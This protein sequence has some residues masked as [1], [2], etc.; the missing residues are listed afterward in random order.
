MLVSWVMY[1]EKKPGDA[2]IYRQKHLVRTLMSSNSA[3]TEFV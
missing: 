3:V 2:Y 1:W